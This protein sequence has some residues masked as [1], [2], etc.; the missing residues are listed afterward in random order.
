L[1]SIFIGL[2]FGFFFIPAFAQSKIVEEVIMIPMSLKNGYGYT[3]K[4]NVIVTLFRDASRN[5][6]PYIILNHGRSGSA[7]DREKLW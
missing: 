1:K 6:F 3:H 7:S 5:K 4:H 2:V